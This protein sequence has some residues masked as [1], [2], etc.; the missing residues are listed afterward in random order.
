MNIQTIILFLLP[1]C[2]LFSYEIDLDDYK[3]DFIEYEKEIH[4]PGYEYAFNPAIFSFGEKNYMS[5]RVR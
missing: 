1:F 3:S 2:C 4:I 5:F